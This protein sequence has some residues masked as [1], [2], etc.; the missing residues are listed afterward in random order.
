MVAAITPRGSKVLIAFD[1]DGTL[2]PIVAR[3]ERA[4]VAKEAAGLMG[5]VA[6]LPGIRVAVLTARD[7]GALRRILSAGPTRRV[8]RLAQ[9]GLEGVTAPR[10]AERRRWRRGAAALA[11]RL[12]PVAAAV[13]GTELEPKGFTVALHD[14]RVPARRLPALRRLVG[15]LAAEALRL[16]FAPVRGRR[17][18]EFVPRGY[19]KG[20][21]LLALRRRLAPR[22]VFYFGDSEADESAFAVLGRR[23]FP[24]RVGSGPS[25]ARYRVRGPKEVMR[26]LRAISSLRMGM[27]T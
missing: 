27:G 23:D 11:R 16:G 4:R 17:V 18:T 9:Y 12:E 26:F 8:I 15:G 13:P 10:P 6:R 25:R 1:V 22:A 7:G 3:P 24:V 20:R 5:R 14:R 2:A 19:D 21:A